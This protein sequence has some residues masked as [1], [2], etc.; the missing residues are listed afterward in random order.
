MFWFNPAK[1]GGDP[2]SRMLGTAFYVEVVVCIIVSIH[3]VNHSLIDAGTDW[4]WN[5]WI[6]SS[7]L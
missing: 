7:V 4:L 1:T 2:K 5:G 6:G 3:T